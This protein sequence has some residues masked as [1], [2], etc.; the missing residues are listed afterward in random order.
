MSSD[1]SLLICLTDEDYENSQFLNEAEK[2]EDGTPCSH[3]F[4][5]F[6]KNEKKKK[7]KF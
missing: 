2:Q 3:S 1:F 7:K 4:R 6:Y 5:I